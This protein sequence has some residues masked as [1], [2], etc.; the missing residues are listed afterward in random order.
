[1][2]SEFWCGVLVIQHATRMLHIVICGLS[3]CILFFH[4]VS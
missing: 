1:M 3:E 2:H 4:I